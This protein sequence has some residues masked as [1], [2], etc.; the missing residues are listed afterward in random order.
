MADLQDKGTLFNSELI[1]LT[2]NQTDTIRTVTMTDPV[3]CNNRVFDVNVLVTVRPE[4][5]RDRAGRID[6]AKA[7]K[8]TDP[9]KIWRFELRILE[10]ETSNFTPKVLGE[11]TF[12]DLIARTAGR[13]DYR[14]KEAN[15]PVD[16]GL[17]EGISIARPEEC[18]SN[19]PM[20]EGG[21]LHDLG[22]CL[23]KAKESYEKAKA[24][25]DRKG[26]QL[27]KTV[28]KQLANSGPLP[29]I[30]VV[31]GMYHLDLT[32]VFGYSTINWF[33]RA[34]AFCDWYKIMHILDQH[35][36]ITESEQL[37]FI[38]L[39]LLQRQ[40][41]EGYPGLV[42][43]LQRL[44]TITVPTPDIGTTMLDD[45]EQFVRG[46]RGFSMWLD[47]NREGKV[48]LNITDSWDVKFWFTT[49]LDLFGK[50][51]R[52]VTFELTIILRSV[53]E[54]FLFIQSIYVFAAGVEAGKKWFFGEKT[55]SASL[56]DEGIL[57][58]KYR[59]SPGGGKKTIQPKARTGVK[60][61][62]EVYGE[63]HAIGNE[64]T[65]QISPYEK[66]R[67]NVVI[68]GNDEGRAETGIAVHGTI[69]MMNVHIVLSLVNKPNL[70]LTR[71]VRGVTTIHD[72]NVVAK[73]VYVLGSHGDGTA[74]DRDVCFVSFGTAFPAC[75]SLVKY[76]PTLEEA[77][78]FKGT[79][80]VKVPVPTPNLS[81][82]EEHHY[83]DL[84]YQEVFKAHHGE[85]I[86]GI[87]SVW[88]A[89]GTSK[90]GYCGS[91][92]IPS[93]GALSNK[94]I[95]VHC[96]V[97]SPRQEVK[98]AMI[99]KEEVESVLQRVANISIVGID[100]DSNGKLHSTWL[101]EDR[102]AKLP[103]TSGLV[104][105]E[106]A[107]TK[108]CASSGGGKSPYAPMPTIG[109]LGTPERTPTILHER[110]SRIAPEAREGFHERIFKK[111][112]VPTKWAYDEETR[113]ACEE[114]ISYTKGWLKE[115]GKV[116]EVLDMEAAI[117]EDPEDIG[118]KIAEVETS[119]G[120]K[121]KRVFTGKGKLGCISKVYLED[122]RARLVADNPEFNAAVE[123]RIELGKKSLIPCDSLWTMAIKPDE[124]I[125]SSKV[126]A[127]KPRTIMVP[128]F[129]Y[130]VVSCMFFGRFRNAVV[131]APWTKTRTA[132]GVDPMEM[133]LTLGDDIDRA[134]GTFDVDYTAYDSTLC[135]QFF[136]LF[137]EYI[138]ALYDDS[139]E[140]K[141]VRRVIIRE[142]CST[143]FIYNNWVGM[144]SHGNPSG[145]PAGLTTIFNNFCNSI[146]AGVCWRVNVPDLDV[147]YFRLSV[148]Y[149]T[150][151]DDNLFILNEVHQDID[152]IVVERF[153]AVN[154]AA[155]TAAF[156][157]HVTTASKEA[158]TE[159]FTEKSEVSFL[160][161]KFRRD[162]DLGWV[163][164]IAEGTIE[165]LL[166]YYK[167]AG[168]PE[169]IR[170][171]IK[172]A[173]TFSA[174][175][176]RKYYEKVENALKR[177]WED[178][179]AM[180]AFAIPSYDQ[181]RAKYIFPLYDKIGRK[182]SRIPTRL[183]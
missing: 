150:M 152:E 44:A 101:V 31:N 65:D 105:V 43:Y 90:P 61:L 97:Y 113:A 70:K 56:L 118:S 23:E 58:G 57:E 95:G 14:M 48:L 46:S 166:N 9:D 119:P 147:A 111:Y 155:I 161:R 140:N 163:P 69:I 64:V 16:T 107:V 18:F 54:I 1:Y 51:E 86:I 127:G 47:W 154:Y 29:K 137:A 131:S 138:N 91:P 45:L 73:N 142:A 102:E 178:V 143:P 180:R 148:S 121:W 174:L 28:L 71:R 169:Q 53:I 100:E 117:N 151:G 55:P 183:L 132:M 67:D 4:F 177:V 179:P 30:T 32:P 157:M 10:V 78:R 96:G 128:P 135:P 76:F 92:W 84:T 13:I 34:N 7:A 63:T 88:N 11:I 176:D 33:I 126:S 159:R 24:W 66:I 83:T 59:N 52:D 93:D 82:F 109:L 108:A 40:S 49:K 167:F 72:V 145:F 129:D 26:L 173:L 130:S 156:G 25:Y 62:S 50:Y 124:L 115:E 12:R 162:M 36:Y 81:S 35:H 144:D 22:D 158:V 19:L 168:G 2:T 112:D 134:L 116:M 21:D 106:K 38:G 182:D 79:T 171:N 68:I 15:K 5:C 98:S 87:G 110:D 123:E 39:S 75:K 41:Y 27:N 20:K 80:T 164:D 89:Y 3:A 114:L 85:R 149:V 136:D 104:A 160:K 165:G 120:Y 125:K 146:L 103:D 77:R 122:G 139:E 170:G 42:Y 175:K 141:R 6:E 17:I 60:T 99:V 8:E 172:D 153:N 94:L 133:W 74:D 181:A 37:T